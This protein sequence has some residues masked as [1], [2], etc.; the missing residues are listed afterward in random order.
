MY[1]NIKRRVVS[2]LWSLWSFTLRLC[3]Q[4]RSARLLCHLCC[5]FPYEVTQGLQIFWLLRNFI[6][7]LGTFCWHLQQ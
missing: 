6:S 5:N 7:W 2:K 3:H 1:K 4:L